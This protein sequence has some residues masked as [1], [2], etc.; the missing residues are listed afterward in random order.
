LTEQMQRLYFFISSEIIRTGLS[1]SF[2]EM[3]EYM[4]TGSKSSIHRLVGAL[5]DRGLIHRL[6]RR[7]RAITLLDQ[8]E[9]E[10]RE[11]IKQARHMLLAAP[12]AVPASARE[13][14][15]RDSLKWESRP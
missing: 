2:A 12:F 10:A 9:K 1:P 3:A 7:A 11:L 5:E 8:K 4:G 13:A 14:W 15:V 6:N